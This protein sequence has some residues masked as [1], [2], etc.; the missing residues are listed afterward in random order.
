MTKIIFLSIILRN[1]EFSIGSNNFKI[2][3]FL[4][5]TF[6]YVILCF[7]FILR[8]ITSNEENLPEFHRYVPPL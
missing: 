6:S 3:F 7:I 1:K 2:V 4:S 8:Q 5:F